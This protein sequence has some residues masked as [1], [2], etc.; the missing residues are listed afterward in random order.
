MKAPHSLVVLLTVL[1]GS[2]ANAQ[3]PSR[4]HVVRPPAAEVQRYVD[5]SRPQ[6]P[7]GPEWHSM[8]QRHDRDGGGGNN[9]AQAALLL[10]LLAAQQNGCNQQ[11]DPGML[12]AIIAAQQ[13]GGC[14]PNFGIAPGIGLGLGCSNLGLNGLGNGSNDEATLAQLR[15]Q[16]QVLRAQEGVIRA[17]QALRKA[18]YGY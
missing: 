3:Q 6:A 4:L 18:Q 12:A 16:Q 11:L 14:G 8:P 1:V 7:R 17:Q 9:W 2:V 15:Q 10:Q 13:S 5:R